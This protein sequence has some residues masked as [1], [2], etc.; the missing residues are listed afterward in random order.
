LNLDSF[1]NQL[2]SG[3]VKEVVLALNPDIEGEVISRYLAGLADGHGVKATRLAHGLPVGGD[4]EF[5][6]EI[7]LRRALEGRKE[8]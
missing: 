7:T 2:A 4:I 1:I 6:D 5:A 8:I 3:E